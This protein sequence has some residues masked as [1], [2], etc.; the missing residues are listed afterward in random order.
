V[1]KD[2]IRAEFGERRLAFWTRVLVLAIT[3]NYALVAMAVFVAA[4][5]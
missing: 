3:A 4:S 1:L 2:E 5:R